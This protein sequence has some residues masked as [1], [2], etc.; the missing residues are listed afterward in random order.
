M[1]FC[2][3]PVHQHCTA[4]I[5]ESAAAIPLQRNDQ[6]TE[7]LLHIALANA[8]AENRALVKALHERE[9]AMAV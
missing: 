7:L 5:L 3:H 1:A 8:K 6:P 4:S 2:Q 9:I